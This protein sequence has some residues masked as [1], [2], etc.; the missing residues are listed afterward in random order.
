MCPRPGAWRGAD[1][2]RPPVRGGLAQNILRSPHHPLHA[3]ADRIHPASCISV[4]DGIELSV[5]ARQGLHLECCVHRLCWE[6]THWPRFLC[7]GEVEPEVDIA[8]SVDRGGAVR[9]NV[10]VRIAARCSPERTFSLRSCCGVSFSTSSSTAHHSVRF[11]MTTVSRPA[12][13]SLDML[14]VC[15]NTTTW[16][17]R[18]PSAE[19]CSGGLGARHLDSDRRPWWA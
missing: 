17:S 19:T 1:S 3:P 4:T 10:V 15:A 5:T 9:R 7:L 8:H 13:S 11:Q 6:E 14:T 18:I 2:A 16:A 12:T